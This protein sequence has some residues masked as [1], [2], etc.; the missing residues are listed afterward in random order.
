MGMLLTTA[1]RGAALGSIFLMTASVVDA[2][3][4]PAPSLGLPDGPRVGQLVYV[5]TTTGVKRTGRLTGIGS[6]SL[7]FKRSAVGID[8]VTR[9]RVRER[10]RARPYGIIGAVASG[11][12]LGTLGYSLNGLDDSANHCSGLHCA[13]LPFA[14]IGAIAGYGIGALVGSA[15]STWRDVQL[16]SNTRIPAGN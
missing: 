6:D 14:V 2:Q 7:Y 9:M 5:E 16:P 12:F 1:H 8:A 13:A 10:T 15:W 4:S 11:L 3:S